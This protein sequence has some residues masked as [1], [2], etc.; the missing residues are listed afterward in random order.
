MANSIALASKFQPVLDDVFKAASLTADMDAPTKPVDFG[1]AAAVNVFKTSIVGMGTYSRATGYPAGDVTG[2]WETLTLAASRGRAFSIDRMDNEETLG[3]AFG[4]LA[5]EFIRTQVAPEVDAYR[6]SKY[7]SWSGVT[8]VGTPAALDTAAKVLAAFDVAMAQLDADEVP[9]EGR[10]LFISTACY[11]LLKASLSRSLA[12]ENTADRRVMVLDNV[13]V[14]PVPQTRF[15]KGITLNAGSSASAG[16]FAKTSST[17]RDINF[18]LLH[19]SAVLQVTKL[20]SLK[21]FTPE[22]N[23][24]ADAWLF[25]YRL[26]H[27]AFVY[28]N[29]VKGIYSHITTS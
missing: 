12:N 8:E 29:H 5:G 21:I 13:K 20:A 4:T 22:E 7:A 2:T 15:Y 14:I 16:G 17:G 11:N 25:Q 26:Y 9:A 18:L 3:Q 1:G 24:T 6:F 27:D 28:D 23:Q 10:K 19:P